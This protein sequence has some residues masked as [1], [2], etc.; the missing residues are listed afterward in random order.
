MP[1]V[2]AVGVLVTQ[3]V[4]YLAASIKLGSASG[5]LGLLWSPSVWLQALVFAL[6]VYFK[7]VL[8]AL[9]VMTWVLLVS[10]FAPRSPMGVAIVIPSVLA[11]IENLLFGSHTIGAAVMS[12]LSPPSMINAGAGGSLEFQAEAALRW[13]T[14]PMSALGADAGALLSTPG[15]W[16]GLLVAAAF[17]AAAIEVR[18]RRDPSA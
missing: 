2:A 17:V 14:H 1:A 11:L 18:R 6:Y 7:V 15:F 13:S 5:M 16:G 12:R 8:W 9:P 4:V 10:A 3:L